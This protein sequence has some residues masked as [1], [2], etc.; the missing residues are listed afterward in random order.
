MKTKTQTVLASLILALGVSLAASFAINLAVAQEAQETVQELEDG[1]RIE[2]KFDTEELESAEEG[3]RKA[4]R[5]VKHIVG[6]DAGEEIRKELEAEFEKLSDGEKRDLAK[7][8]TPRVIHV[9]DDDF[10]FGKV[11]VA[12]TAIVFTLGMPIIIL[13]LVF[14]FSSRKRRQKMEL[15]QS[16]LQANQPVP[17]HVMAEFAGNGIETPLRKGL[18]AMGLG[19]GLGIFLSAIA[20]PDVGAVGLI[21]FFIGVARVAHWYLEGRNLNEQNSKSTDMNS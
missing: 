15:V 2:I 14:Y 16:Y 9:G 7:Q 1:Q 19:L 5:I 17:E 11:L 13:L 8:L 21:P 10:G 18:I 20:G 3:F 6:E 12:T 4:V